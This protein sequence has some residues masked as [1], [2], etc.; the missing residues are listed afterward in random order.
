[1][2]DLKEMQKRNFAKIKSIKDLIQT[3]INKEFSVYLWEVSEA[4]DALQENKDDLEKN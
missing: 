1:M 2:Y 4:Y 3:D